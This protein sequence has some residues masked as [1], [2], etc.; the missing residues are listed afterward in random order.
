ME[1][2]YPNQVSREEILG[3]LTKPSEYC[4]FFDDTSPVSATS[5]YNFVSTNPEYGFS[6]LQ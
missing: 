6:P 3:V 1:T 4:L 2:V 5:V